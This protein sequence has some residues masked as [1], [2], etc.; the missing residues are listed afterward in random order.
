MLPLPNELILCILEFL[1]LTPPVTS[2]SVA[3]CRSNVV[4]APRLQQRFDVKSSESFYEYHWQQYL[5]RHA[6][7]YKQQWSMGCVGKRTPAVPPHFMHYKYPSS[8]FKCPKSAHVNPVNLATPVN[9]ASPVNPRLES[10]GVAGQDTN[11]P[12]E[13]SPTARGAA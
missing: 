11:L 6:R 9:P 1:P 5:Q 3:L 13:R 12:P 2:R 7:Q 8:T 10:L 4:W